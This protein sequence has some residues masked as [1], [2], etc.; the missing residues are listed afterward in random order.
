[1]R[2]FV[3][4]VCYLLSLCF[5]IPLHKGRIQYV[6]AHVAAIVAMGFVDVISGFD[7]EYAGFWDFRVFLE[8]GEA[9]G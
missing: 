2:V 1:M 7:I 8:L 3:E 6:S 4:A 9:H 5:A